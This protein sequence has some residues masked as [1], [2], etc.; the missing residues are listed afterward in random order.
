M[1]NQKVVLIQY[2]NVEFYLH[3]QNEFDLVSINYF[4]ENIKNGNITMEDIYKWCKSHKIVCTTRFRY[5]E[6]FPLTAN[7]W[8]YYSYI[9]A[10]FSRIAIQ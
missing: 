8:N 5:R 7:L 3:I 10:K 4:L 2:Y 6:D 1:N 9:R